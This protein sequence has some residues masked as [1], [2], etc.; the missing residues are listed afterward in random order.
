MK[1][2]HEPRRLCVKLPLRK[3]GF[4]VNLPVN[5]FLL[6][7]FSLATALSG[8]GAGDQRQDP[9]Y[10]AILVD[11]RVDTSCLDTSFSLLSGC[12]PIHKSAFFMKAFLPGSYTYI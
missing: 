12:R 4:A 5:L 3:R 2:I 8:C 7:T 9:A 10:P 6:T 1:L 11:T